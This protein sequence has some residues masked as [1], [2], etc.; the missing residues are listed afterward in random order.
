MG[1]SGIGVYLIKADPGGLGPW[2]LG[3]G[4]LGLLFSIFGWRRTLDGLSNAI[5]IG[6]IFDG[7]F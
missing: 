5:D 3:T 2:L 7:L 1:V 6:E 4:G